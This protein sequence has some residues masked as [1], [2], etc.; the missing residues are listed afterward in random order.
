MFPLCVECFK[1]LS[2]KKIEEHCIALMVEWGRFES[3]I[4]DYLPRIKE[5]IKKLKISYK[6]GDRKK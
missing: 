6:K 5:E 4:K 3:E 2:S 1:K